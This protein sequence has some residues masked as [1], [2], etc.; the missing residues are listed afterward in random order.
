[1]TKAWLTFYNEHRQT[2]LKGNFALFGENYGIPDMMFI[3]SREAI[4][5][6][7]TPKH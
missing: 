7:V 4:V 2:L 3:G 1:M 6:L 5:Y